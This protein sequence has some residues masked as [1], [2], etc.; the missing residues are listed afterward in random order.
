MKKFLTM[1]IMLFFFYFL[2]QI[3]FVYLEGD[4]EVEYTLENSSYTFNIKENLTASKEDN[5][6][7]YSLVVNV[8]NKEF[9][10]LTFNNFNRSS[11]IVTDIKYINAPDYSCIF[12]KYRK[13]LVLHDVICKNDNITRYYHTISNPSEELKKFVKSLEEESYES[14]NWVDSITGDDGKDSRSHTDNM[15]EKH[16]VGLSNNT[17]FYRINKV[18]GITNVSV[19]NSSRNLLKAFVDDKYVMYE[20]ERPDVVKFFVNNINDRGQAIFAINS[21][22]SQGSYVLGTYK[23]SINIFDPET[24]KEFEVD[25]TVDNIL[26]VGNEATGISYYD[27]GEFKRASVKDVEN[28]NFG[29]EYKNDLVLD[30]Y[31]KIDKRGHKNGYYYFYKFNGY[32]YD[33]YRS[34]ILYKDKLMYVFTTT[35]L[36]KIV[37]LNDYVY[38]TNGKNILYYNDLTG[39]K[40][41]VT[42]LDFVTNEDS[43][44]GVY[45]D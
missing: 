28:I 43:I 33:V 9:N 1:L 7:A 31:A 25:Y 5:R 35:N 26:E 40:T 39:I 13:D 10:F 20:Y 11:E 38:F 22:I 45:E 21:T 29:T 2:F 14:K 6:D 19:S 4:H 37:Y 27:V 8:D 3:T 24:K 23:S 15:V 12:V 16:Y 32:S 30:G 18:D 17:G 44:L 41:I 36:D 42:S 34:D